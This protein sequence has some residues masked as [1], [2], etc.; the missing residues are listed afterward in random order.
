MQG[1]RPT[2]NKVI[3]RTRSFLVGLSY[4]LPRNQVKDL[5]TFVVNRLNTRQ[6]KALSSDNVC[7]RTKLTGRK[8]PYFR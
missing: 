5:V 4:K 3:L 7:P 2:N 1:T 8:I 6:T